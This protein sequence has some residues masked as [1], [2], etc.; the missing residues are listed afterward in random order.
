MEAKGVEGRTPLPPRLVYMKNISNRRREEWRVTCYGSGLFLA[1]PVELRENEQ[2]KANLQARRE[3]A[4]AFL[5]KLHEQHGND[6]FLSQFM[7]DKPE[8]DRV[9]NKQGFRHTTIEDEDV[10]DLV[11]SMVSGELATYAQ[12]NKNLTK[13]R[14]ALI[15]TAITKACMSGSIFHPLLRAPVFQGVLEEPKGDALDSIED[16]IAAFMEN[17][18]NEEAIK[19]SMVIDEDNQ[20]VLVPMIPLLCEQTRQLLKEVADALTKVEIEQ[21][22]EGSVRRALTNV[23]EDLDRMQIDLERLK[24]LEYRS[25]PERLQQRIDEA[26]THEQAEE[27]HGRLLAMQQRHGA[28]AGQIISDD[29]PMEYVTILNKFHALWRYREEAGAENPFFFKVKGAQTIFQEACAAP[30]CYENPRA[31]PHAD[32]GRRQ[33]LMQS[34]PQRLSRAGGDPSSSAPSQ[35]DLDSEPD[36]PNALVFLPLSAGREG[37]FLKSDF[38]GRPVVR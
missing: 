3:M 21:G 27:E 32:R 23:F 31:N 15:G 37:G 36:K 24:E 12:G 4:F 1:F 19:L 30:W 29:L 14:K 22:R 7:L 6:T 38:R 34:G 20:I 25:N 16:A 9:Q 2:R 28:L 10:P 18:D 11:A 33:V 26:S 17:P 35:E 5:R 8:E 13:E